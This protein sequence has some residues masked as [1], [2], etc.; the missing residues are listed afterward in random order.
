MVAGIQIQRDS[1]GTNFSLPS[2]VQGAF[3][4]DAVIAERAN[5]PFF[6]PSDISR[7]TNSLG[8]VFGNPAQ[9]T[10]GGGPPTLTHDAAL[11]ELFA[12]VY[13]HAT[14]RSRIFRIVA[15]GQA[16]DRQGLPVA[17]S[18]REIKVALMPERDTNGAITK[19]VPVIYESKSAN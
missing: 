11:E 17:T 6:S 18:R 16:L 4:A 7:L 2:G 13:P 9:W 8:A 10:G 5:A 14:I 12:K 15:V 1:S 19:V 3:F